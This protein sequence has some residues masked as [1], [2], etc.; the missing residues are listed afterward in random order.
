[1]AGRPEN[2]TLR[3]ELNREVAPPPV[4]RSTPPP[5]ERPTSRAERPAPLQERPIKTP[6]IPPAQKDPGSLFDEFIRGHRASREQSTASELAIEAREA[7]LAGNIERKNTLLAKA[8]QSLQ[9]AEEVGPSIKTFKDVDNVGDAVRYALGLTGE[10]AFSVVSSIVGGGAGRFATGLSRTVVPGVARALRKTPRLRDRIDDAGTFGGASAVLFP[11]VK[12]GVIL[13]Q[14]TDPVIA[15]QPVEDREAAANLTAYGSTALE[16]AVPAAIGARVGRRALARTRIT[17]NDLAGR[18]SSKGRFTRDVLGEGLTEVSQENLEQ[19][20]LHLQNPEQ[21]K[22]ASTED[23]INA[24]FGGL[25]GGGFGNVIGRTL[26]GTTDLISRVKPGPPGTF[27]IFGNVSLDP[28]A[29][30]LSQVLKRDDQTLSAAFAIDS[31]NRDIFSSGLFDPEKFDNSSKAS[32]QESF[33]QQASALN[34]LIESNSEPQD[35]ELIFAIND[36]FRAGDPR[37]SGKVKL[38]GQEAR[39]NLIQALAN[40]IDPANPNISN[41]TKRIEK[42]EKLL[43]KTEQTF[44]DISRGLFEGTQDPVNDVERFF[45]TLNP[46]T[47]TDGR[48]IEK[49]FDAIVMESDPSVSRAF[50]LNDHA[51]VSNVTPGRTDKR[52]TGRDTPEAQTPIRPAFI[53]P[54]KSQEENFE[55]RQL[56]QRIVESPFTSR[57]DDQGEVEESFDPDRVDIISFAVYLNAAGEQNNT[58]QQFNF[59]EAAIEL[60]EDLKRRIKR[61][62]N[63][64]TQ[65]AVIE[66]H[67]QQIAALTEAIDLEIQQD[68]GIG[69]LLSTSRVLDEGE[70]V[71]LTRDY[72]DTVTPILNELIKVQ[73]Q[74]TPQLIKAFNEF[75]EAETQ[76]AQISSQ[77]LPAF[78]AAQNN[79]EAKSQYLELNAQAKELRQFATLADQEYRTVLEQVQGTS[80]ANLSQREKSL[81]TDLREAEALEA[82]NIN[83]KRR[84]I[85]SL[86]QLFDQEYFLG[87][88]LRQEIADQTEPGLRATRQELTEMARGLEGKGRDKEERKANRVAAEL[89]TIYVLQKLSPAETE[90][91]GGTP[92]QIVKLDPL[93]VAK[94]AAKNFRL[95]TEDRPDERPSTLKFLSDGLASV[96]NMPETL[97]FIQTT[98]TNGNLEGGDNQIIWG[99][100]ELPNRNIEEGNVTYNNVL[101]KAGNRNTDPEF[102]SVQV[103]QELPTRNISQ[104]HKGFFE[105]FYSGDILATARFWKQQLEL[106]ASDTNAALLLEDSFIDDLR[107]LSGFSGL[108]ELRAFFDSA[109]DFFT[110]NKENEI[111]E[112]HETVEKPRVTPPEY[113]QGGG[114]QDVLQALNNRFHTLLD[115]LTGTLDPTQDQ[116]E[117]AQEEGIEL[118]PGDVRLPEVYTTL[119]GMVAAAETALNQ[120]APANTK[121]RK[122]LIEDID[123]DSVTD[124]TGRDPDLVARQISRLQTEVQEILSERNE[125]SSEPASQVV[126]SIGETFI[127]EFDR[128]QPTGSASVGSVITQRQL[129]T[130]ARAALQLEIQRIDEQI[131]AQL[132]AVQGDFDI[133]S[134]PRQALADLY[135][136]RNDLVVQQDSVKIPIKLASD[137]LEEQVREKLA[138]DP[139]VGNELARQF[140]LPWENSGEFFVALG[141]VNRAL[142]SLERQ[143]AAV[144]RKLD[145]KK[146]GPTGVDRISLKL[147]RRMFQSMIKGLK[148]IKSSLDQR[149]QALAAEDSNYIFENLDAV[150]NPNIQRVLEK[151]EDRPDAIQN[152]KFTTNTKAA[153]EIELDPDTLAP[154]LPEE[155]NLPLPDEQVITGM[156]KAIQK[157]VNLMD[158]IGAEFFGSTLSSIENKL[159]SRAFAFIT[160]QKGARGVNVG[161]LNHVDANQSIYVLL[162]SLGNK[163]VM[164]QIKTAAQR[165]AVIV[166]SSRSKVSQAEFDEFMANQEYI[167][168]SRES[169]VFLPSQPTAA[170]RSNEAWATQIEEYFKQREAFSEALRTRQEFENN[171][172]F[173]RQLLWRENIWYNGPIRLNNLTMAKPFNTSIQDRKAL[174][175]LGYELDRRGTKVILKRVKTK[176][177]EETETE[178]IETAQEEAVE[179]ETERKESG[180]PRETDKEKRKRKRKAEQKAQ[181]REDELY[182]SSAAKFDRIQREIETALD[183]VSDWRSLKARE[184]VTAFFREFASSD[185]ERRMH[186][187][188]ER[189]LFRNKRVRAQ[190]ATRLEDPNIR[191][192]FNLKDSEL[193]RIAAGDKA[194]LYAVAFQLA[195]DP[196][197]AYNIN[198]SP[199]TEQWFKRLVE[200]FLGLVG[201]HMSHFFG[202]QVFT[203]LRTG[204]LENNDA[205]NDVLYQLRTRDDI[206]TFYRKNS[207]TAQN[208]LNKISA[209][210]NRVVDKTVRAAPEVLRQLNTPLA[211]LL[212]KRFDEF[213]PRRRRQND[214]WLNKV[215]R[216]FLTGAFTD[217]EL[218]EGWKEYRVGEPK[219]A[220]ARAMASYVEEVHRYMERS[221]VTLSNFDG[222][223]FKT[224]KP[225]KRK[226]KQPSS[227]KVDAI[228]N[229][230]PTL[231]ALFVKHGLDVQQAEKLVDSILWANG[232]YSI[233][234]YENGNSYDFDSNPTNPGTMSGLFQIFNKNNIKE[235]EPFLADDGIASLLKF[236]RQAVHKAEFTK[237]FGRNGKEITRTLNDL[238]ARGLNRNQLRYIEDRIIPSM[239]GTLTYKM[240][241]RWRLAT[242]AMITIQNMAILPLMIFPAMVDIW[243]ISLQTGEMKQGWYSFKRGMREIR[244]SMFREG[245]GA[246]EDIA[247]L[248]GIITEQSLLDRVGDTYNELFAESSILRKMNQKFFL[249]T[250]I[251]QWTKGMRIAALQASVKYIVKHQNDTSALKELGLLPSDISLNENGELIVSKGETEYD[252][253]MSG[254]INKFVD[255]AV[256]RPSAAHRPAWGSDPRWL[257]VWHLKQFT[258]TFHKVW[259]EKVIKE[260]Q[261]TN[262]NY[263]VLLPFFLMVPT[264]MASDAIKNIIAPSAFYENMSFAETVSNSVARSSVL[265][266]GTF[267]LDT[268]RDV[269]FGKI[270]GSSLLG[271]TADSAYRF[272]DK[273]FGEGIWRLTPGFALWNR[274]IN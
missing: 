44:N 164:N 9:R 68:T 85:K 107:I 179:E 143:L 125:R 51:V 145:Q 52:D 6:E 207:S 242:G 134:E 246:D 66:Q 42:L 217:Q 265:G 73:S 257:L 20:S 171:F 28:R 50:N 90:L 116:T 255:S 213:L 56:Q 130:N 174:K 227:F 231:E 251:E 156:R 5:V 13:S 262:P 270:P 175:E 45:G 237:S 192:Q 155:P 18:V 234:E 160:D 124:N 263:L 128:N 154:L 224:S 249:L 167:S 212:A 240:H 76:H 172:M 103:T 84:T 58:N 193:D 8:G 61:A 11:E 110:A 41:A 53:D 47:D 173:M 248:L 3:E 80:L 221:N 202:E 183:N 250:G 271:P 86:R 65:E 31:I 14:E 239:L 142:L 69:Q 92:F 203:W 216:T 264:M 272:V 70:V 96:L 187:D 178:E 161:Q 49:Q 105:G 26:E 74:I 132:A 144:Q 253:R 235:F 29:R 55:A 94:V 223:R 46:I 10:S 57:F 40:R 87:S 24:F 23:G 115:G 102:S 118:T 12:G 157:A 273:G 252:D 158:G 54:S 138:S 114:L 153:E 210:L 60:R 22:F 64:E 268:M 236:T 127:P 7:E 25:A 162:N 201:L 204:I 109:G 108:P 208:N 220:A 245:P 165:K 269:E 181:D 126:G 188:L 205:G 21:A 222:T 152:A 146:D 117:A 39:T 83:Q 99:E 4:L 219:S 233:V 62:N 88:V 30:A 229:N 98:S 91:V 256:L 43:E 104:S 209:D 32:A 258:F 243:G 112:T 137:A 135:K 260:M 121:L 261:Q 197:P 97:G 267:G 75:I 226:W 170:S 123:R 77:L 196:D 241:P 182:E 17:A 214:T 27:G 82:R 36:F 89:R 159:L 190:I 78:Q 184:G 35:K 198:L 37:V 19:F 185:Q 244:A 259:L 33:R 168:D 136:R 141:Q 71:R 93:S 100:P 106:V 1:M 113:L 72:R 79:P 215:N 140:T 150:S 111:F 166:L 101:K 194:L 95:R 200:Y 274:W 147:R 2:L 238:G 199:A 195:T 59:I 148:D 191:S 38:K 139:N 149:L 206:N 169:N 211:K 15:V 48:P 122:E 67:S 34:E 218:E 163:S 133:N 129:E 186:R 176:K 120:G 81:L 228:A 232:H 131:Q 63:P 266:I 119:A 16:A 180:T 177:R 225:S 230:R 247:D 151:A 254:A 189:T